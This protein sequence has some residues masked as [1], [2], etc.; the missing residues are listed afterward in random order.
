VKRDTVRA[1]VTLLVV[2]GALTALT[3]VFSD[4]SWRGTTA[5]AILLSLAAVAAARRAGF[6]PVASAVGSAVGLVVFTY[7]VHLPAGP[8][9][10]GAEQFGQAQQ[11]FV[12]GLVQFRD[13][14]AP[15][16]PLPGLLL[17]VTTAVWIV[18]QVTHELLVRWRRPGLALLAPAVLWVVPLAVPL[19]PGRTWPQA[20]P[21]LAAAAL[22]LLVESDTD[23]AGHRRDADAP[24]WSTSG[25]TVGAAALTVAAIVPAALPG[26]GAAAWLDVSSGGDSRGY[27]PIVD[28][29]DRLKL[30]EERPV[31]E[32]QADRRTYLRLAAL[33]TFD[34]NTWRLGPADQPNFRPDASQLFSVSEPLPPEVPIGAQRVE[35]NI[36]VRVLDLANIYVPVPYQP[37]EVDGVGRQEMVY[38]TVGGFVATGDLA[39]VQVGGDLRVGVTEGLTYSVRS[40]LPTPDIEELRQVE[41]SPAEVA[42]YLQ[43]PD[44]HDRLAAQAEEVYAAAGAGTDV[45]KAFALQDW[46]AGPGSRF[47]YSTEVDALRGSAALEDFVFSTH[48]GYCEYYATAMAVMLRATGVPARVAVGFLPGRVTTPADPAVGRELDTYTVT[49]SDAHAWVEVLF[50]GHGWIKFDPTPRSDGATMQ[51]TRDDLDPLQTQRER[52]LQAF[53]DRLAEAG[54]D[55]VVPDAPTDVPEPQLPDAESSADGAAGTDD[56]SRWLV[57]LAI[58]LVV[59]GGLAGTAVVVARRR[60]PATAPDG[61]M[62]VLA[63]QQRVLAAAHGLGVARRPNETAT[64]VARRWASEG[65]VDGQD[66]DRFASLCQRAAFGDDLPAAAGDQADQLADRLVQRLRASVTR[67]DR[68]VAPARA[69]VEATLTAGR[70]LADR[71]LTGVRGGDT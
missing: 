23:V 3:R 22:L 46:F 13:E 64:E 39:E 4:G 18:T 70:E 42:P 40:V 26:Y 20:L 67:R 52:E 49:T 56:G 29:G 7:V 30:P 6:G 19:P 57:W 43:L 32:V 60:G 59:A 63:A 68:L 24:A 37:V 27:Q 69:P 25:L 14:P 53:Q 16:A 31:L 71:V 8:L 45:D 28:V 11:L 34:N 48:T 9:I 66:A 41:S 33:D 12:E 17:I 5:A 1:G 47:R 36:N 54:E 15:T 10:P 50:P 38:S 44:G 62:R 61:A 55:E 2:L 58:A 21:F 35:T 51:P 65:R